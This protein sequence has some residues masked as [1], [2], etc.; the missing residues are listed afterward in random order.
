M[1]K[2]ITVTIEDDD[3]SISST[4]ASPKIHPEIRT[5]MGKMPA[6]PVEWFKKLLHR[7]GYSLPEKDSK[8]DG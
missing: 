5:K 7:H 8:N 2:Y 3:V 6:D 4:W 1:I